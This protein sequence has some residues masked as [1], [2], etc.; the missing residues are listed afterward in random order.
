MKVA[1]EL[2]PENRITANVREEDNGIGIAPEDLPYI[3]ELFYRVDKS[4]SK[5]TGGYGLGLN[6]CK[7][8][9]DAD[10]GKIEVHS[11]PGKGTAVTLTFQGD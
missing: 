10:G 8:I 2:L 1:L 4:R 6:L 11:D 7:T 5:Q 3:F 9:M